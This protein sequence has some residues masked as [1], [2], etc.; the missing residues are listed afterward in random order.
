MRDIE[1]GVGRTEVKERIGD[2]VKRGM[3]NRG[4]DGLLRDV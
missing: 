2:V 4:I 1:Y 3:G